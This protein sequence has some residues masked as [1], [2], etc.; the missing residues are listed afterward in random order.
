[1]RSDRKPWVK[2]WPHRPASQET[3]RTGDR[4]AILGPSTGGASMS[5]RPESP[6]ALRTEWLADPGVW[7][8]EIIDASGQYV[9][10]SCWAAGWVGYDTQESAEHAAIARLAEMSREAPSNGSRENE[11]PLAP[12]DESRRSIRSRLIVVPRP[13]ASLYRALKRA[14][15]DDEHIEVVLDRRFKERRRAPHPHQPDRRD[16]D[17]RRRID[18]EAQLASGRSVTIP[19]DVQRTSPFD[20]DG[21]AILF[22]CCSE[23]VVGCRTC[24]K[25]YRIRWLRRTE[26]WFYFCPGCGSDVTS[27][28]VRHTQACGYWAGRT[29]RGALQVPR[30]GRATA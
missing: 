14:F 4:P 9:V 8:W 20:A 10:E 29:S 27:E 19:I 23:H 11:A 15:C 12:H 1:M 3:W 6:L 26:Q 21:R 16:S 5:E 30:G 24:E 22:L 13:R 7:V 17:R 2:V 25:T 18:V 28:I